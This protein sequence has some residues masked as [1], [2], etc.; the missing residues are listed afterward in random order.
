M[1]W[2]W[3]TKDAESEDDVH[4]LESKI[5]RPPAGVEATT[6]P[7]SPEAEMAALKAFGSSL[8]S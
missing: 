6:G 7:W 2:F 5:Y 8:G 1:I 3:L 4:K